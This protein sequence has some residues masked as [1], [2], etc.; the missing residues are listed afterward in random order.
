[1]AQ[2]RPEWALGFEDETWFS[3][4]ERPSMHSWADAGKPARLLEKEARKGDP[5]PKA[6]LLRTVSA[7]A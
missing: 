2:S 7:R 1:L 6:L 3:R 5:E 4:F